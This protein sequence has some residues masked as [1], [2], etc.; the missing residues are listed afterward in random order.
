MLSKY[1][2]KYISKCVKVETEEKRKINLFPAR[3][4]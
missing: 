1:T 4:L 3:L 2:Y